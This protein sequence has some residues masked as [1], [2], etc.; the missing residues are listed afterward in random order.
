M[1]KEF[2]DF[3]RSIYPEKGFIPLHTPVFNGKEKQYVID[4][5]DSTFVSSIGKYVNDIEIAFARKL[6]CK[7]AIAVVNGTSALQIALKL[8]GV[9]NNDLVLTQALTFVATANAITYLDAEPY[10]L[11]VDFDTMGMSPKAL[12]SFLESECE[13]REEGCF[14]VKTNQKVGACVPMHTF[15]FLCRIEDIQRICEKWKVPLVEDSAEALGSKFG[16]QFAGTFGLT[17]AFSFNGNK[18][19]TS[20]GGGMIATNNAELGDLAKHLTTTAKKPHPWEYEHDFVGYN[21]RMPNINAALLCAQLE[22]L[23]HFIKAKRERAK[24]L[25]DF[26]EK[27]EIIFRTEM[28]GTTSNY[29]LYTIQLRNREER[30]R[31]LEVTNASEVMTRPVW[32][33]LCNLQ[34]YSHCGRDDQKNASALEDVIVNIPSSVA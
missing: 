4:T 25:N 24:M 5:I 13:I 26:F 14:Y 29:W 28:S 34:I 16:D 22:G 19:I 12:E 9:K 8:A 10:F 33:L 1:Y 7:K 11:D 21:F 31:F 30:D 15:G 20:G 32:K 6:Q 23:D 2:I 27:S 3:I 17:S 18:I